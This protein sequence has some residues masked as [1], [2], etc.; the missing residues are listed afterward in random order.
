MYKQMFRALVILGLTFFVTGCSTTKSIGTWKDPSFNKNELSNVL[1]IG[2]TDK[3]SVR[4]IFEDEFVKQLQ[5]NSIN[6]TASYTMFQLDKADKDK[7]AIKVQLEQKGI[8]SVIVTRMVDKA[9]E[10]KYYPPTVTY[11]R[12]PRVYRN[13]WYNYYH[14]GYREFITSPGYSQTYDVVKL[15]CNVYKLKD[16]KLLFSGLSDTTISRGSE[17]KVSSIVKALIKSFLSK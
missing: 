1:V 4:R 7:D 17:A 15:E 9:T 10:E 6:A 16:E 5:A 13:G 14:L 8:D 2:I 11:V 3:D 12:P